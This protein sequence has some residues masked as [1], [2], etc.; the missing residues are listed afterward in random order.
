MNPRVDFWR[1]QSNWPRDGGEFI[2]LARAAN[3]LGRSIFESEWGDVEFATEFPQSLP[4]TPPKFL[5]GLSYFAHNLLMSHRPE[6][7]R[8]PLSIPARGHPSGFASVPLPI[9]FSADEWAAA[10]EISK[11]NYDRA[12]PALVRADQVRQRISEMAA[13][14]ILKTALR[15]KVGGSFYKVPAEW[16]NTERTHCRFDFCQMNP[17]KPFSGGSAGDDY[18]W[19][20]VRRDSLSVAI[21]RIVEAA[22]VP[23]VPTSA[24]NKG[25][26]PDEYNWDEM[27]E[28]AR[29]LVQTKG[30][31]NRGN[32]ALPSKAQLVEAVT[33]EF[34]KAYD[35]HPAQSSV[36]RRVNRWLSE[37]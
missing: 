30:F 12:K 13:T 17:K 31:P 3:A 18:C 34:A 4:A 33:D 22:R 20:Y 7:K 35:Q 8:Q 14:G 21:D 26:R 16:W 9:E 19:I 36:R 37:F 6:F 1:D 27:K 15:E 11:S 23:S 29:Q 10:L 5:S 25:G 28:F 2:F 32:R 24:I